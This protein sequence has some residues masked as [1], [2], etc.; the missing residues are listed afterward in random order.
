M[1]L[2][3][4]SGLKELIVVVVRR[5]IVADIGVD[6]KGKAGSSPTVVIA[7]VYVSGGTL[8]GDLSA[9][10]SRLQRGLGDQSPEVWRK[11][12]VQP[13]GRVLRFQRGI[14]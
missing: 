9:S 1:Q 7:E 4:L 13:G 5:N 6:R 14:R 8:C 12:N 2:K 11:E 3:T 10:A